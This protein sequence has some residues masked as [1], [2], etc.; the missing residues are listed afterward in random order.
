MIEFK[1]DI[2]EACKKYIWKKETRV[3]QLSCLIVSVLFSIVTVVVAIL[4][5]LIILLFLIAFAAFVLLGSIP[6]KG[7][8]KRIPK[9]IT[10]VQNCLYLEAESFS[11][12]CELGD[13]KAIMDMGEWYD[14]EFAF[15][16]KNIYFVCQKNLLVQ[17]A[18]EEFEELFEGK[19]VRKQIA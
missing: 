18:I 12:S 6:Q 17:G 3:Q 19:I 1:G 14:I 15:P 13:V 5:E 11:I 10:V 8:E 4:Y 7:I 9:K 16:R 2:S